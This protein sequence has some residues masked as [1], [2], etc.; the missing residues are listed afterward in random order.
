MQTARAPAR[1]RRLPSVPW[2]RRCF[3]RSTTSGRPLPSCARASHPRTRS[4]SPAAWTA[5]TASSSPPTPARASPSASHSPSTGELPMRRPTRPTTGLW[6]HQDFMKLWTGQSIS[7]FGTQISGLAIPWLAAVNLH[8]SPFLFSLLAVVGFLP[9]ILF[10]LP[11]GVW[12]DRLRR[13]PILIVGDAGRAALLVYIP[14]AWAGGWLEI[15]Q[16]LVFSF[17]FGILTVFFDVAYQS[18]LPSLVERDDLVEGNSKLQTTAAAARRRRHRR[19]P[20]TLWSPHHRDHRAVRDR[21][22]RGQL[23]RLDAVH[24]PHS[25]AGDASGRPCRKRATPEDVAGAEGRPPLRHTPPPSEVDRRV[26]GHLELLRADH[27]R[28]RPPLHAADIAP[29]LLLGRL[30][31]RRSRD[32]LDHR[33]RGVGALPAPRRR[34]RAHDLDE[35]PPLLDRGSRVPARTPRLCRAASLHRDARDRLRRHGLQHRPGELPAGAPP[36]APARPHER[37]DALDR[38]GH[39]PARRPP[40]RRTRPVDDPADGPL[41]RRH[42]QHRRLPARRAHLRPHDQ[43][44]PAAGGRA[45]DDGG[46]RSR[47]ARRADDTT[48]RCRSCG[49]LASGRAATSGA[50]AA[51]SSSGRQ[52]PSASSARASACSR[53]RSPRCS[54]C[55]Q[56]RSRSHC[57]AQPPFFRSS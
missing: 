26:Y 18:Y 46:R 51:S 56:A 54:S 14:I 22:R 32:R 37:D 5:S 47:G 28:D 29:R 43:G 48:R 36:A 55:T 30:R 2:P 13:R 9:F 20:T 4:A 33:R 57:C 17:L 34:D 7:E 16:L 3:P 45:D 40:R 44:D 39:D 42:R 27:L 12:V 25:Q 19:R 35:L 11:A 8:V 50:T 23:R 24:A 31:L 38:L 52:T 1:S 53:C 6:N 41:G 10:A 49:R 15:Y 21:R